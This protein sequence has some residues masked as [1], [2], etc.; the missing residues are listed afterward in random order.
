MYTLIIIILLYYR[1]TSPPGGNQVDGLP[2]ALRGNPAGRHC[3][4]RVRVQYAPCVY[5]C[6]CTAYALCLF[7]VCVLYML[8]VCVRV[9]ICVCVG[10]LC[11]RSVYVCSV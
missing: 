6:A 1:S 10:A 3:M 7:R 4:L 5:S 2:P 8:H 11:V 9:C